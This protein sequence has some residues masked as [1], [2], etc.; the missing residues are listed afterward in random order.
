MA[1][2]CMELLSRFEVIFRNSIDSTLASYYRER[3]RHIPWFLIDDGLNKRISEDINE[4]RSKAA[5]FN[6]ESRDHIVARLTFG[7]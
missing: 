1:A 7:F 3:D 6:F 2:A 4:A 5:R